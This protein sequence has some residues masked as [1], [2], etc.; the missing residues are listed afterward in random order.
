MVLGY[1]YCLPIASGIANRA[2]LAGVVVALL[3]MGSIEAVVGG[4]IGAVAGGPIDAAGVSGLT[5]DG[6][7]DLGLSYRRVLA[8][9]GDE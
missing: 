8:I 5:D 7:A 3:G 9:Y 6:A 1:L 4:P 2:L